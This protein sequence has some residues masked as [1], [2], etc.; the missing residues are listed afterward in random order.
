M[1]YLPQRNPL[2]T[3]PTF[4]GRIE[5]ARESLH[6]AEIEVARIVGDAFDRILVRRTLPQTQNPNP[7]PVD[8]HTSSK[9][10]LTPKS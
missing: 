10:V 9:S 3:A 8:P 2:L 7:H 4:E 1:T 5:Q 6:Q